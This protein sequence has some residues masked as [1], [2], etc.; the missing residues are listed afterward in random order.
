MT[1]KTNKMQTVPKWGGGWL[2]FNKSELITVDKFEGIT[3][4][5]LT[6]QKEPIKIR[7][8]ADEFWNDFYTS[9]SY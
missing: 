1:Y 5:K 2:R 9:R 3:A 4:I 7:L 6:T 8:S